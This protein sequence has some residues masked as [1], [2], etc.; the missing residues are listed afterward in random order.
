LVMDSRRK[1]TWC[2]NKMFYNG[3]EQGVDSI[4]IS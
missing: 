1:M 4:R 2:A 3:I